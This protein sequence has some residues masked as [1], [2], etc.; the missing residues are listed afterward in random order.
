MMN[1]MGKVTEI[2]DTQNY[3]YVLEAP[4]LFFSVGYKVLMGQEKNGFIKCTKVT[5]NGKDKLIYDTSKFKTLEA[6]MF[7][8]RIDETLQILI[9]LLEA[10]I[11]VKTNGFMQCENILISPDHI[12]VNC[13]SYDINLIYLPI[14]HESD[15]TS[16]SIFEAE[17]KTNLQV[18]LNSYNSKNS[19]IKVLC[20]NMNNPSFTIEDTQEALKNLQLNKFGK[21][22]L[23]NGKKDK[24][25]PKASEGLEKMANV[26]KLFTFNKN[27]K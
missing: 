22:L 5:H 26:K 15:N 12:F 24:L 13:D 10:I 16:Y 11:L 3:A 17:L 27:N 19:L 2:K 20:G 18:V 21:G 4:S 25:I 7:N 9:N 8:L 1:F 23:A 14:Y 6:L